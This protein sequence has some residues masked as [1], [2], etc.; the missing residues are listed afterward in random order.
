MIFCGYC[1][2]RKWTHG[3]I[4]NWWC[5]Y[6]TYSLQV[7]SVNAIIL[8]HISCFVLFFNIGL[9]NLLRRRSGGP[10]LS[11]TCSDKILPGFIFRNSL[12]HFNGDAMR[13]YL[14]VIH[15]KHFREYCC[16]F[17]QP[18]PK[19]NSCKPL[20]RSRD[21]NIAIKISTNIHSENI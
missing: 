11:P 1:V 14:I 2:I 8:M 21:S 12:Q 13:Y 7:K 16:V 17:S 15:L 10:I 19:S 18:R 9:N 6:K 20:N 5:L 3:T 4:Q